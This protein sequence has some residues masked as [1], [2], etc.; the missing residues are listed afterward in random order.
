MNNSNVARG[1]KQ[2]QKLCTRERASYTSG[3]IYVHRRQLCAETHRYPTAS[4]TCTEPQGKQP[5]R[6][7]TDLVMC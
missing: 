7:G 3:C 2:Q 1:V 5:L 6:E 4:S